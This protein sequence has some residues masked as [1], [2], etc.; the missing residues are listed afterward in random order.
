MYKVREWLLEILMTIIF[1]LA[2]RRNRLGFI[3]PVLTYEINGQ[4]QTGLIDINSADTYVFRS[5]TTSNQ[6]FNP[7]KSKTFQDLAQPFEIKHTPDI[8]YHSPSVFG[9]VGEDVHDRTSERQTFAVIYKK[10]GNPTRTYGVA[11]DHSARIGINPFIESI[12]NFGKA[13]SGDAFGMFA[14]C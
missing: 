3:C 5:N 6:G 14:K 12:T 1:S 7:A 8:N 9:Y 10:T 2:D 11:A 13:I 4:R